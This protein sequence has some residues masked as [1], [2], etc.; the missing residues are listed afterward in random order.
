[1][2]EPEADSREA[3]ARRIRDAASVLPFLAVVLLAP[4]IILI[5]SAPLRLGGVP[6]IVLY[7]FG[8][9]AVVIVAALML[10]RRLAAAAGPAPD[11]IGQR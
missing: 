5:F 4:P 2:S 6:L 11:E 7:L 10:S 8:V 1:L 3:S 9:W